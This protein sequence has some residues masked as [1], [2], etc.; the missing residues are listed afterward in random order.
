MEKIKTPVEVEYDNEDG[1]WTIWECGERGFANFYIE[2]EAREAAALIN[3]YSRIV[4]FIEAH[5][6]AGD[7]PEAQAI[8]DL[9]RPPAKDTAQMDLPMPIKEDV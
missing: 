1:M 5:A 2:E 3:G 6:V 8:L 7:D 9:I 4:A